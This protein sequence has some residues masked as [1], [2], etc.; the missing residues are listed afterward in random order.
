MPERVRA[1][2][3]PATDKR[4]DIRD[5]TIHGI[6]HITGGG[7]IDNIARILPKGCRADI[8]LGSWDIL[9]IFELL[10]TGGGIDDREMMRTFNNGIGLVLIVAAADEEEVLMRLNALQEKAYP[11][12]TIVRADRSAKRVNFTCS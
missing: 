7:L 11:I 3:E 6:A 8:R 10:K 1:M 2:P 4:N 5:F 9:P 12:G